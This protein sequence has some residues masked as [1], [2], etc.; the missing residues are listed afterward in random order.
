MN[1]RDK[2]WR[3]GHRG[4]LERGWGEQTNSS[5]QGV[6]N[7]IDN[8][9]LSPCQC[10]SLQRLSRLCR[11]ILLLL[12][13]VAANAAARRSG[14]WTCS[15]CLLTLCLCW[16]VCPLWFCMFLHFLIHKHRQPNKTWKL[17]ASLMIAIPF[18]R[19][20]PRHKAIVWLSSQTLFPLLLQLGGRFYMFSPLKLSFLFHL[21][22]VAFFFNAAQWLCLAGGVSWETQIESCS[23]T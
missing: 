7:T 15:V 16:L 11:V 6:Q 20:Q 1:D 23:S 18:S 4:A 2:K 21:H 19:M 5:V 3:P 22:R 13:G 14:W 9:R 10:Q 8:L 12:A 17:R